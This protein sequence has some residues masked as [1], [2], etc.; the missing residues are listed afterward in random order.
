MVAY[1]LRNNTQENTEA[2]EDYRIEK[3]MQI[4]QNEMQKGKQSAKYLC[5]DQR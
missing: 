4:I 5:D 1:K 3:C 2:Y